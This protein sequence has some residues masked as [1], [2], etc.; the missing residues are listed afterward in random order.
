MQLAE[1]QR[2]LADYQEETIK[3]IRGESKPDIDLLNELIHKANGEIKELTAT[4]E[5]ARQELDEH[6]AS[7]DKEQQEYDKLKS[8][9][10]RYDNCTF[11]AKKM[12]VSQFIKAVYV[13]A[14][15]RGR[16]ANVGLP[17]VDPIGIEPTTL[18]MRTQRS[19]KV[20]S[21]LPTD[22]GV[23]FGN[24]N[25]ICAITSHKNAM[26]YSNDQSPPQRIRTK[27]EILYVIRIDDYCLISSCKISKKTN[28]IM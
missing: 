7:A 9:A 14:Q 21:F 12:I 18:R 15:K 1:K 26:S 25:H 24:R 6:I 3:V 4:V 23:W 13:T 17:L 28:G 8:R 16:L 27:V 22:C 11:A 2:E 5:A 10:D 20:V 19:R